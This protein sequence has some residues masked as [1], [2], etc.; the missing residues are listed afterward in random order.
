MDELMLNSDRNRSLSLHLIR[1]KNN[2]QLVP[3]NYYLEIRRSLH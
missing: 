3:S 1:R 2:V